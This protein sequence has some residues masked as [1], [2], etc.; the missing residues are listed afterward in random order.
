MNISQSGIDLIK[1]FEG[2]RLEAYKAVSTEKYY[3]IGYGHYGSDVKQGQRITGAQAEKLLKQDVEKFV[4]GVNDAV[5]VTVSQNQF[6][7]LVSF[8]YNV[9]LG[10][11]RSSTLLEKLNKKDYTGASA[12]FPRWNKSGGKVLNGLVKRREKERALFDKGEVRKSVAKESGKEAM[13][14]YKIKAGDTLSEIAKDY[15]TNITK[16]L[17]L[18]PKIKKAN[19][20]YAGQSITVPSKVKKTSKS[21]KIKYGDTLSEIA[22]DNG[23]T[24]A[25][26]MKKNPSIKR[27]NDIKAGQTIQI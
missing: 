15:N 26:I 19:L 7:A 2:L 11:L 27:A 1:S 9:G 17:Q 18:N 25:A 10:A 21:Y 14:T 20:I 24:V 4:D 22:A 5:K 8:A 3:T 23:T 12:E 6:D 13:G 16:L